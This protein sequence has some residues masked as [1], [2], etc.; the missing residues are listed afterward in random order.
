VGKNEAGETAILQALYRL[1]PTIPAD[2]QFDVTYD[3]PKAEV[4]NY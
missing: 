2:R 3:Y 4:E 1:N